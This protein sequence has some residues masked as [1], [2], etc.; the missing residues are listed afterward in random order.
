MTPSEFA[1]ER[2]SATLVDLSDTG[3]SPATRRLKSSRSRRS[4]FS[5]SHLNLNPQFQHLPAQQYSSSLAPAFSRCNATRL[6]LAQLALS[7]PAVNQ[8]VLSLGLQEE[9]AGQLLFD[10][11]YN[12]DAALRQRQGAAAWAANRHLLHPVCASSSALCVV[13][14]S[15]SPLTLA[16]GLPD[17]DLSQACFH[18]KA[19]SGAGREHDTGANWPLPRLVKLAA[20]FSDPNLRRF[21]MLAIDLRGHGS[22]SASL[23]AIPEDYSLTAAAADI[24]QLMVRSGPTHSSDIPVWLT[25][26]FT[27]T[28]SVSIELTSSAVAWARLVHSTWL[29]LLLIGSSASLRCRRYFRSRCVDP[30]FFGPSGSRPDTFL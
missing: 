1:G 25:L 26:F 23:A 17:A 24:I 16:V 15:R 8:V 30:L 27:R 28:L 18:C 7:F 22:S 9:Q 10:G 21:N 20:Q 12:L 4:L 3:A 2:L 19:S 6:Y 13:Q 5:L 29:T 11:L 14:S